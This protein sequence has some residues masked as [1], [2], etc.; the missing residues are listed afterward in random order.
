MIKSIQVI[1]L[2]GACYETNSSCALGRRGWILG[3][4]SVNFR[5]RPQGDT[6]DELLSNIY[7]AAEGC[8]SVDIE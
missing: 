3:R 7:E 8:L 5:L 1:F 2:N 4:S 6:F